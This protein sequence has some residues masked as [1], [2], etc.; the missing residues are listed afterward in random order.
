MM[1]N[2]PPGGYGIFIL[3]ISTHLLCHETEHVERGRPCMSTSLY[4]MHHKSLA[5]V[6]TQVTAVYMGCGPQINVGTSRCTV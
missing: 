6:E 5:F 1:I 3:V 4:Q 2:L